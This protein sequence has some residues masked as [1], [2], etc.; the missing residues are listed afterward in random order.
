MTAE[1]SSGAGNG[2]VTA[3]DEFQWQ[4]YAESQTCVPNL[5]ACFYRCYCCQPLSSHCGGL[6]ADSNKAVENELWMP[7]THTQLLPTDAFGTIQ[8]QDGAHKRK[9]QVRAT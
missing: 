4:W 8:F 6:D 7:S 2:F 5:S 9:A 3:I 1:M